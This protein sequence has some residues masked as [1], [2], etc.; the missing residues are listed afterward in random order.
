MPAEVQALNEIAQ[1]ET[2]VTSDEID[3]D[4]RSKA[5]RKLALLKTRIEGAYCVKAIERLQSAR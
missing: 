2:L 3:A 5:A 4:A 1:L